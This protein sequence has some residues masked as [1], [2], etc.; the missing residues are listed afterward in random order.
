MPSQLDVDKI[1]HTNGT[2]ALTFDTS[3]NTNL[4]KD[5][6]F[7]STAAIKNSAGNNILSESGGNVT[8]ENVRL[9]ASGGIKDSSGNNVLSESNNVVSISSGVQFPAGHVIQTVSDFYNPPA[10][11]VDITDSADDYLGS[12]LEVVLTPTS[13]SNKLILFLYIPDCYNSAAAA[14]AVRSGFRYDTNGFA[15][16]LPDTHLGLRG[17]VSGYH[18][19]FGSGGANLSDLNIT[20]VCDVPTISQIT[21]RPVFY[22]VGGVFNLCSNASIVN[23]ETKE[24]VDTI[25]LIVQEVQT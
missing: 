6:K 5:L 7:G 3:G 8:L 23:S 17:W 18:H 25:S 19:Y 9:P 22:G 15:S 1:R 21:I 20:F 13:I 16:G 24:H 4:Q 11:G 12:N 10:G 14:R 2:D